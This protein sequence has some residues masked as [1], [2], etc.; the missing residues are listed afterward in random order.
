MKFYF[1]YV[2][3]ELTS[4]FL[5]KCLKETETEL[6]SGTRYGLDF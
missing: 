6:E 1:E 5:G 3:L 4:H 2:E